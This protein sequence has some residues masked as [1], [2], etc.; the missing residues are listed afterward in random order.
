MMASQEARGEAFVCQQSAGKQR[1]RRLGLRVG[2]AGRGMASAVE[3]KPLEGVSWGQ[4]GGVKGKAW[5]AAG[6]GSRDS[7][8]RL[9]GK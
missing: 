8:H 2:R 5:W 7:K 6:W 3:W 4:G 1:L 9:M